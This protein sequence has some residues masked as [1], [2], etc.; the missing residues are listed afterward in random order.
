MVVGDNIFV[1]LL[2]EGFFKSFTNKEIPDTSKSAE[3]ILALSAESRE[4][5]DEMVKKATSSGGTAPNPL[6]DHGWM[7]QHGFQD[8]DGHIW[9]VLYM[10]PAGYSQNQDAKNEKQSTTEVLG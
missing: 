10:D 1:M 3:V 5:V 8:P 6:Q 4:K 2:V 7:Y 9:E